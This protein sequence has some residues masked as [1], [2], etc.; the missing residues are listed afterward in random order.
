VIIRLVSFLLVVTTVHAE[1]FADRLLAD[2]AKGIETSDPL[3]AVLLA[4]RIYYLSHESAEQ[5]RIAELL[6]R[7]LE[8]TDHAEARAEI[9]YFL[10]QHYR[11]LGRSEEVAALVEALGYVPAW[12][13]MGPL[14]PSGEV[15]LKGIAKAT[16]MRGLDRE[17]TAN[18]VRAWGDDTYF[19]E[20]IGHYGYFAGNLAVFPNQLARAV[21]STWFYAPKRG[22]YRLGMGWSNELEAYVNR[23][24]VFSAREKQE[25][26]PDQG[27]AHFTVSRGWHRLSLV[28]DSAAEDPNLGFFA[29]LTD[30]AGNPL[31]TEA[32]R[33]NRLPRKRVRAGAG[34]PSLIE[35]ARARSELALATVLL[36]KEQKR[37]STHPS[38][39]DLLRTALR[40]NPRRETVERLLVLTEDT[41]A[42]W[43]LLTDY[44][45]S[46]EG[47]DRAWT[48]TQMGQIALDQQRYWQARQYARDALAADGNYWPAEVLANNVF[49]SLGLTG[50]ALR[51]TVALAERYPGVPWLMMDLSDLYNR[52]DYRAEAEAQTDAVLAIRRALDKFSDRKIA[53]LVRRGDTEALDRFY[54]SLLEAQPYSLR[55]LSA[56][57]DFLVNNNRVDKAEALIEGMLAQLPENPNLLEAM[58][59]LKMKAGRDGALPYLERALA[60][61]PQNPT[62]E[63]MITLTQSEQRAFYEPYRITEPS[64]AYVREVSPIVVNVDNRVRKVAPNGQSTYYHQLEYEILSEQGIKELPGYAFSYAPLREKAEVIRAEIIRD[65]QVIHLTRFGRQRISDP[66]Y[67]MYYDLVSYQIAFT[68]LEVGDRVCIE[69]RID[70]L[71][72]E[73]IYGDYFGDQQYFSNSY[74]TR[75]IAYTLIVPDDLDIHIHVEKMI[76]EFSQIRDGGDLVYRWSLEPVSPYETESRMPGV[77]GYMPYVAVSTFEDW[78]SMASWY[79][80]LVEDQLVLDLETR[81]L[82]AELTEG[83]TDTREIV[84][85]IHEYVVTNTRYVALEFGIHGYKPYEVNQV[86]TRQFGDCK[87]K[88]SLMVA[89][90]REAGVEAEIAIV[91][92]ADKGYVHTYPAMLTYFN[93]AIAYVP[94]LDLYL[95]GTAELSG[96]DEL[97]VMD[98]GALTLLVDAEGRGELT[99]IPVYDN[100]REQYALRLSL[101]ASGD[102]EIS[103]ELSFQGAIAPD[104]RRYLSIDTR[105]EQ[106][107]QELVS[108]SLPGL[109]VLRAEREGRSINDPITL[110]FTGRSSR[111]LQTGNGELR[112]PLSILND[113]LTR[114]YAPNAQRQFPLYFGAPKRKSVRLEV[115]APDGWTPIELP[116]PLALENDDFAVDLSVERNGEHGISVNYSLHFKRARVEPDGYRVLREMMQAHDRVLDQA[117]R[118]TARTAE[119]G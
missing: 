59:A 114:D 78:Q 54:A 83:I 8:A 25:P 51:N 105:L 88:A 4:E 16:S 60:L 15:D 108:E 38:P 90:M 46:A 115:R 14:E 12:R 18:T 35:L 97:P 100:T 71:T 112:L 7:L 48:L 44:L 116:E 69:Y 63:K 17:V 84:E 86:C 6:A 64:E 102:A 49:S 117:I 30:A 85:R 74:P 95:D 53:F 91:R 79:Q 47:L 118:F 77:Q 10:T 57:G 61:E 106:D 52:M 66:A 36:I 81:K 65:G 67:R 92:T 101:D 58:G 3:D 55:T 13:I 32:D 98:Q 11:Q 70:A 111:V 33:R 113:E 94:E 41:N 104:V 29:R 75:Q 24:P 56:Y 42:R 2:A 22:T 93:H 103:G 23:T 19:S 119:G 99:N 39:S 28:I 96:M 1:N 45:D 62:L 40:E 89:M 87:D 80:E 31:E 107:L 9:G 5:D 26:H 68:S 76:P 20:G 34:E 27:I 37:H 50:E 21:Y 72:S 82:V 73:N 109:D 43:E 110:S